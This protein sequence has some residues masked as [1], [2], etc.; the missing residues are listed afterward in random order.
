[1]CVLYMYV[2]YH[3]TTNPCTLFLSLSITCLL[4]LSVLKFNFSFLFQ[5]GYAIRFDDC[6][7]P[8]AT[9]IKVRFTIP[10]GD[11]ELNSNSRESGVYMH[12]ARL[13][14]VGEV[15][16]TKGSGTKLQQQSQVCTCMQGDTY[17]GEVY[18]TEGSGDQELNSNSRIGFVCMVRLDSVSKVVHCTIKGEHDWNWL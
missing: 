18:C 17:H 5:V 2:S 15:Y 11:Q 14:S 12:A 13:D 1:M 4:F 8:K 7:D 9:R 6:T 16:C 10:G 3:M